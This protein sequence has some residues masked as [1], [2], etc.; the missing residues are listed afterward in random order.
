MAARRDAS[1]DYYRVLGVSR[2][3]TAEEIKAAY[4]KQVLLHHP[5]RAALKQPLPIEE[6]D[7]IQKI[8]A[9]YDTLNDPQARVRYDFD[10]F[11]SSASPDLGKTVDRKPG[12]YVQMTAADVDQMFSGL[13]T[14]E[15]FTTA[16]Y[17]ALR[18]AKAPAAIGR[19]A[20]GF[21]ERKQFRA[22][23]L[24]SKG[25]SVAWLG[26]PLLVMTIWGF[27]VRTVR[28]NAKGGARLRNE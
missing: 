7:Q 9:A 21:Q 20:T 5:D 24:P 10:H 22:S 1:E 23:K 28:E 15:R 13:N 8:N 4:R 18:S 26:F 2:S 11:G 3:A 17:H 6:D 16:Q 12:D 25:V 19:R 27:N 14:Y